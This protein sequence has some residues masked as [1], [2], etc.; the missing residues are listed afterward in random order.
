M[1]EKDLFQVIGEADDRL[2]DR[3][4]KRVSMR[5]IR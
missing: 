1:N 2:I 3:S 4:E 5:W